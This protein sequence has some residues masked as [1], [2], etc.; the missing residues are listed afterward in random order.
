MSKI[1]N[2]T[3]F[4]K[5]LCDLDHTEQRIVAAMFV[6]HVLPLSD[7]D[8]LNRVVKVASKSSASEDELSIALSSAK[9][10]TVD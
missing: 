1:T 9:A 3:E 4:K 8:R 2:D 5:A 6:S 10:A 7:D